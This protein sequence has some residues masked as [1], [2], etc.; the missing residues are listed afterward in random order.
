M[1]TWILLPQ[2]FIVRCVILIYLFIFNHRKNKS[3]ASSSSAFAAELNAWINI[4]TQMV[5]CPSSSTDFNLFICNCLDTFLLPFISIISDCI[6]YLES[7][8]FRLIQKLFLK[9]IL[10]YTVSHN[11]AFVTYCTLVVLGHCE[12]VLPLDSVKCLLY[13]TKEK[14]SN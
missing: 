13:A 14:P 10:F 4:Y 1:I 11:T 8:V 5:F 2:K 9:E 3:P 6:S 7:G 12:G